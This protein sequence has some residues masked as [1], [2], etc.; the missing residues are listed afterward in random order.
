MPGE[1]PAS[2]VQKIQG[3]EELPVDPSFDDEKRKFYAAQTKGLEQDIEERKKYAFRIFVLCCCW[4]T[5]VLLLIVQQGRSTSGFHVS[6]NIILAAIG[7]TTANIISVFVIVAK[8][9]F[10]EKSA[11]KD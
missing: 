5:V 1:N 10:P 3:P 2:E 4:I 8:H 6:D 7:S 9:L 11:H